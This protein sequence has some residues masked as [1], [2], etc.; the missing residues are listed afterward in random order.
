MRAAGAALQCTRIEVSDKE[1][2][3]KEASDE[4]VSDKEVSQQELSKTRAMHRSDWE[5][6]KAKRKSQSLRLLS[7]LSCTSFVLPPGC[8]KISQFNRLRPQDLLNF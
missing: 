4:E 1:V 6:R 2:S 5:R 3:D 7:K 8:S